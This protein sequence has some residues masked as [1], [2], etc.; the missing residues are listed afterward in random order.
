MSDN[1]SRNSESS[2]SDE[3]KKRPSKSTKKSNSPP[4]L[5]ET[6]SKR[7]DESCVDEQ[8]KPDQE[9]KLQP[10]PAKKKLQIDLRY[11]QLY[12][13]NLPCAEAYE[14]SYMHRDVVT[15]VAVTKTNFIITGS[16]DGHV[17]FWKKS[18]ELVEF[19]KHFRAHLGA[20]NDLVV[21]HSGALLCT[22]A[23][24]KTMKIFD[25]INFDMINMIK[26]DFVV[27]CA[28]WIH[29]PGDAIST[30]AVSNSENNKIYV[31]DGQSSSTEHVHCFEHLH[32]KPVVIMKIN[33]PFATVVSVDQ[34]GIIEYWMTYKHQFKFPTFVQ[35]ESKL[36]TS[37]YEFAKNKTYPTGLSFSPD[38]QLMATLAVDRKVRIF[39][40]LTGK[41]KLVI[42][43]SLPRYSELQQ[44]DPQIPHM[45]FGR[46]MAVERDIEKHEVQGNILFDESG[47]MVLYSTMLGVKIVSIKTGKVLQTIGKQENLRVLKFALFQGKPRRV[48]AAVTVEMEA[49]ENPT[50][51]NAQAD[52]MLVCTA[53][54]KNR[55]YLFSRRE[56]IESK[57]VDA[58][59]D[60][61][62][63]KPSK[64]DIIAATEASATQRIF[65]NAIIHTTYGDIHVMLFSKECPK[66][67]ENFSVHAKDGY[68]N[69]HIFHRVIKSFMIQTGDPTGTGT[70]GESI[71]GGEFE[72]EFHPTLK[73]DRPY[74][75]SMANAGPNTNGSQFFIT[76][77]PTP[78][79][80]GKHTIFG[81]VI[82]GME[83][84][85]NISNVKVDA[86]TDQ[87]VEDISIMS[88]TVK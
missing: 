28:E 37:L 18:E 21:N 88:V 65:N 61:F 23:A 6:S 53:F 40:F 71:W 79:L 20:I 42:D 56:P 9:D 2:S 1:D 43:E 13:D 70:G 75:L 86:K 5:K 54:K 66:T 72:D 82:K 73:H 34:A 19:V 84:V 78:W 45:E 27:R 49:S 30:I 57:S 25:V 14:K 63:E 55:F 77:T 80:D 36:D 26:L 76:V 38:G 10:P 46:R 33:I 62:N 11:Q 35:F 24:D 52:P 15:H 87:P 48:K 12:L 59:R 44:A 17:K 85:Q 81:R 67:V 60:V 74:T 41:L 68:F 58:D 39:K 22:V 16:C 83:V 50:L 29:L 4:P 7:K 32:A 8:E 31:Y 64:E 3:E 69:G 47:S 51:D